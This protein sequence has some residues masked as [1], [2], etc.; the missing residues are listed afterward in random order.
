MSLVQ[1]INKLKN[2]ED[3][4][5]SAL[6]DSL[7]QGWMVS[8]GYTDFVLEMLSKRYPD[9]KIDLINRGIPGDTAESGLRRLRYDVLDKNPH[10]IFIQFALNDAYIGISPG[11]FGNSIRGIVERIKLDCDA[12]ILLVSS[13]TVM[14]PS[15]RQM[16]QKFYD[17]LERI[18]LEEDLS[19]ARVH[20]YWEKKIEEGINFYSLVQADGV[21]PTVDGYRLMAE[22]IMQQF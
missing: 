10:C 16:I 6:G 8:K 21:H 15:E 20:L 1:T 17:Q 5:I 13:V 22:A 4:L 18:A 14:N 12:E 19:L 2:G 11:R 9:S 7:T 3:L